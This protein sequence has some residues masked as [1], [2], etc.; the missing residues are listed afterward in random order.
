MTALAVTNTLSN[1][2]TI[3][4]SEHNTNYSDIVTYVNNRNSGSSTWDA[5]SVS[6]ASSVP[7]VLNN[8]S[9]TQDIFRAQDNGSNV[10][11][12]PDGGIIT[13]ASQSAARA[14]RDSSTQAI[15]ASST[16]KIQFNAESYDVKSEFDSATNYR[17][18]ATVAGK[19]LVACQLT[20]ANASANTLNIYIYKNGAAVSTFLYS[21]ASTA[22]ESFVVSDII[23]LAATDYIEIF[24]NNSAGTNTIQNGS[25][26]TYLAVH[27]IA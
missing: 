13:M 26:K 15:S 11:V 17:F 18:T 8:S 14:Y 3:L 20:I 24:E 1:G 21:D 2:A 6:S 5:I 9:G 4:A 19:Y 22:T 7:V 12:I 16:T 25:D 10:M 27:K 23:D